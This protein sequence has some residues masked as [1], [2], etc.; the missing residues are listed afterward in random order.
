MIFKKLLENYLLVKHRQM[1][2][3]QKEIEVTFLHRQHR[4]IP[5]SEA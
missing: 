1:R 5:T 4:L 3:K 2:S